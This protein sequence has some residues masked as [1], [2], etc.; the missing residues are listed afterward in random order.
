MPG[1]AYRLLPAAPVSAVARARVGI[2]TDHSQTV[3]GEYLPQAV[4]RGP[5]DERI[6]VELQQKL[7]SV[8]CGSAHALDRPSGH[9]TVRIRGPFLPE[10]SANQLERRPIARLAGQVAWNRIVVDENQMD[11]V[12]GSN[13]RRLSSVSRIRPTS[14]SPGPTGT[15]TE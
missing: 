9:R 5:D 8:P 11:L 6:G 1:A 15:N 14:N 2:G 4:G 12:A 10:G 3:V 13:A 7:G